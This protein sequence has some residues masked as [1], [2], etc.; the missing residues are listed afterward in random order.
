[1]FLDSIKKLIKF[2]S[3]SLNEVEDIIKYIL[4]QSTFSL[5]RQFKKKHSS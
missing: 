5:K 3:T 4:A 2:K 1:M